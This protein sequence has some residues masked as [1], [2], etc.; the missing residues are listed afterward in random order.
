MCTGALALASAGC[1]STDSTSPSATSTAFSPVS[2]G[3]AVKVAFITKFSVAFFTAME[4]SAKAYAKKNGGV[5]ITYFTCKSPSDV[6]CQTAQIEDA[7]AKGFQAIVITP[8]G[9]E[10]IP[11]M[12]AAAD[13][14]LKVILADNNLDAFTKK[15]A[16]AATD[17]VKGGQAAGAYLKS[18][19]KPGDTIGL[20]EGV[21]GV[22]ALEARIKG[23]KDALEG[24]GVKVIIGGAET[25]C[26]SAKG[27][28]VAED[29]LT[30]APNLT[31]IYSACDDPAIAAAKVAKQR[32][33]KILVMGYDGL[34]EAAKAIQAGDMLATIAQFPGKMAALGV[35][36]A[37]SAVQGKSVEPFIDTGTE[38]VTKDNAAKFLT[39]Q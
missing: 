10:V 2:A 30:R 35:E 27:A 28:T 11:A 14:G 9:P 37:V 23:V 1:G 3:G 18:L 6:A 8:M 31:A 29:L 22:P 4:D 36:A 7:V 19:L 25:K 26:D 17:N 21:R 32:G 33:K 12:N 5:D 15:T 38:L 20:M 16:V 39:F 34:P 24:T 13:K